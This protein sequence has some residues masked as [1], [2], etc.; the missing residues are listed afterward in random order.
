VLD[1]PRVYI[2]SGWEKFD[3][4]GHLTDEATGQ[5][6]QVLLEAL[7]DEVKSREYALAS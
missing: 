1:E 6:I 7:L 2:T 5:Q 3:S 4:D